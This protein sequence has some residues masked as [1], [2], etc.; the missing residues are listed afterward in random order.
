MELDAHLAAARVPAGLEKRLDM[1]SAA[2][3]G[4]PE[5]RVNMTVPPGLALATNHSTVPS[6]QLLISSA[7]V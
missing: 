6:A 2:I 3:L 5:D 4:K 7:R 1:A